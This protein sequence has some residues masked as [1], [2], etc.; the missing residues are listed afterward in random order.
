MLRRS[1]ATSTGEV[2]DGEFVALHGEVRVRDLRLER[3]SFD[4]CSGRGGVAE[5]VEAADCETWS[6]SLHD[7]VVRDCT[8]TNL[9]MT[10][11]AGGGKSCPFF[12]WGV[13][14]HRLVLRG[15]IGSLIWNPP[16]HGTH[17][18]G[19]DAAR[20]FYD[21]IDDWALDVSEARFTS[22][23]GLRFGPPG[24]LVLR[25][26]VTQPL[27]TREGATRAL[28]R[29]PVHTSVWTSIL[30]EFLQSPWPIEIVLMPALGARKP[31]REDDLHE[32]DRIRRLGAFEGHAG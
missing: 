10:V 22:I 9:R 11:G 14:A 29:L 2:V 21:A 25:D 1:R 27:V 16:Q 26:P 6:S 31:Q 19:F 17:D 5:R 32:L 4:S 23:P 8:I 28:Q 15:K 24:G 13:L 7:V 18:P 12:L 20:R 30:D 3:C